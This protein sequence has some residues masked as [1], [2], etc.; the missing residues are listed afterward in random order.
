MVIIF[1][2]CE[3]KSVNDLSETKT[4]LSQSDNRITSNASSVDRLLGAIGY[5]SSP[6]THYTISEKSINNA[7]EVTYSL[8][9]FEGISP[10]TFSP[11][12]AG[13]IATDGNNYFGINTDGETYFLPLFTGTYVMPTSSVGL[14]YQ[15]QIFSPEEIEYCTGNMYAISTLNKL[16]KIN[17]YNSVS[18]SLSVV[19][20]LFSQQPKGSIKKSLYNKFSSNSLHLATVEVGNGTL[21]LYNVNLVTGFATPVNTFS[22]AIPVNLNSDVSSYYSNGN[23]YIYVQDFNPVLL[24]YTNYT[25]YKINS[26]NVLSTVAASSGYK[27]GDFACYN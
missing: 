17:N 27:T 21:R 12:K 7:A 25:L 18:P 5:D 26:A 8:I 20:D 16:F 15:S 10:A 23:T 24:G 6:S 4:E 9:G 14:T 1:S 19:G 3:K 2:A 13:T 11:S 22:N